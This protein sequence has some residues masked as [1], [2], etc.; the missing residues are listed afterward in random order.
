MITYIFLK[1]LKIKA[2]KAVELQK[3]ESC[4]FCI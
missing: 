4:Y 2:L 1:Y 3:N